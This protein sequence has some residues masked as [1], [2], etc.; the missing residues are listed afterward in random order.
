MADQNNVNA[1]KRLCAKVIGGTTTAGDIKGETIAEVLD[2][3]TTAFT[4]GAAQ[5]LG[6]LTVACAAG[7]TTGKTKV[8]VTGASDNA[9]FKYKLSSDS[10]SL[11][12]RNEDLNTWATWNGVSEITAEDGQKI[13][14]C[15][16]DENY[17]AL[18]GGIAEVVI[19][20][21]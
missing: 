11:P 7:S 5:T 21:M 15:E 8:T 2:Q 19:N 10:I 16:V 18:K 13:C 3:I 1:L 9:L 20:K 6:S 17:L 12:A 14:V 4:G